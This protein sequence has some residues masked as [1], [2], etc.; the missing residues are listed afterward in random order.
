MIVAVRLSR[1]L[2]PVAATAGGATFF[3]PDVLEGTD[4]M[5]GSARGTG[6]VVLVLAVPVML[7]GLTAALGGSARGTA[8]WAGGLAYLAYNS[9]MFC[10]ATPFNRLFLPYVAMLS[11]SV[12][13]LVA[14]VTAHGIERVDGSRVPARPIAVFLWVVVALNASAWL[15]RIVPALVDDLPPDF[16]EGVGLPTNPVYVQDLA[17]WLPAMAAIGFALWR[18][19]DVGYLLASA[20][21]VFWVL[22]S[23]GV[24]VDQWFGHRA[25]PGSDVATLGG[26]W[27]F[28]GM[29]VVSLVPLW[30][31]FRWTAVATRTG[32]AGAAQLEDP[33]LRSFSPPRSP[34]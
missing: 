2:A 26:M 14:L 25:D 27:L 34:R 1:A 32:G 21:L 8:V 4:V 30:L 9:V 23:V 31:A 10:F 29:T 28:V 22:E 5:N 6:L 19:T 3:F 11:L 7:T 16:L 15:V 13:A 17:I 20:G 18:R 33:E 24:A 12:W